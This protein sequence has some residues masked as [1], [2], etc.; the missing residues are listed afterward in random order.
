MAKRLLQGF[1]IVSGKRARL[2]NETQILPIASCEDRSTR[3]N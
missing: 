3:Y 1:A 2:N